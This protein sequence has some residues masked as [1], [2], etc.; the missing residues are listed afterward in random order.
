MVTGIQGQYAPPGLGERPAPQPLSEA[1]TAQVKSILA[2]YDPENMTTEAAQSI[3][4]AFREAGLRPGPGLREAIS[5][6]GFDAEQ[7]R[8]LGRP[9]DRPEGRPGARPAGGRGDG[10][11]GV[12][13]EA[14]QSLQSILGQYDL[15]NLSND[16]EADLLGQLNNSG[17]LRTGYMLDLSA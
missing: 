7:L 4:K 5:A 1:Q 8:E 2:N 9:N 13:V 6:A 14:L 17:R 15:T 12:N 3:F 11:T 16:Q 10:L